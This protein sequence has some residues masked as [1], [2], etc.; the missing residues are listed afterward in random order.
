VQDF[1]PLQDTI[2]PRYA[3]ESDTEDEE[4]YPGAAK[5]QTKPVSQCEVTVWWTSTP[6][7]NSLKKRTLLVGIGEPGAVWG[8][9]LQLGD[10]LGGALLNDEEVCVVYFYVVDIVPTRDG[11][12]RRSMNSDKLSLYCSNTS[13]LF[14]LCTSLQGRCCAV[15][16]LLRTF[17]Y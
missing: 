8:K 1:D 15:S 9:G 16:S 7:E 13:S 14:T 11:R 2:P 5:R 4:L 6:V 3:L 12:S 10:K 17:S